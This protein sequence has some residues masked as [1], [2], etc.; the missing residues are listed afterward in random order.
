MRHKIPM[1]TLPVAFKSADR[2]LLQAAAQ[3][4]GK[5]ESTFVR[6]AATAVARQLLTPPAESDT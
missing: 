5:P 2:D 1:Q 6:E 3:N 4:L